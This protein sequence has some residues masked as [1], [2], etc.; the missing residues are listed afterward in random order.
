MI[1]WMRLPPDTLAHAMSYCSSATLVRASM[2]CSDLHAAALSAAKA[3]APALGIDPDLVDARVDEASEA[4]VQASQQLLASVFKEELRDLTFDQSDAWR[5]GGAFLYFRMTER[6]IEEA[7]ENACCGQPM[8]VHDGQGIEWLHDTLE[9]KGEFVRA[10]VYGVADVYPEDF[11][12]RKH[13]TLWQSKH[14]APRS[15]AQHLSLHPRWRQV[16]H[17]TRKQRE[18]MHALFDESE[19]VHDPDGEQPMR[20]LRHR[21]IGGA[22]DCWFRCTLAFYDALEQQL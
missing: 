8:I 7:I 5:E 19:T 21:A 10:C 9:E 2:A 12:L 14:D 1:E 6:D 15:F 11:G 17:D 16:A 4:W 20:V 13:E 22:R 3:R 18:L